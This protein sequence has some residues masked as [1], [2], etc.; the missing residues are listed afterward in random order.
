MDMEKADSQPELQAV[1][2]LQV[3]AAAHPVLHMNAPLAHD[4]VANKGRLYAFHV[5]VQGFEYRIVHIFLTLGA[6]IS[7]GMLIGTG[8]QALTLRPF[9]SQLRSLA[10]RPHVCML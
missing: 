5:K 3:S 1:R 8:T 10:Q 2:D 9:E 6:S 7:P 4:I